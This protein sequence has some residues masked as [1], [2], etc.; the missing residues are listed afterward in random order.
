M[1]KDWKG[2]K[3]TTGIN[4][5]TGIAP[6]AERYH[7]NGGVRTEIVS[8]GGARTMR[9]R[10]AWECPLDAYRDLKIINEAEYKAGLKFH[11]AYYGAVIF[12]RADFRPTSKIQA[13]RKPTKSDILLK[14][15]YVAI[16]SEDMSVIIDICGRSKP[17]QSPR[18]MNILK[19]GL[20]H[21]ATHWKMAAREV[22]KRK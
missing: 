3:K 19:R 22:C 8:E 2:K 9:Y 17:A 21:L 13:D 20:G 14:K 10:A 16:P 12:V 1:E 4:V 6:T 18:A 5:R 15:V 11:Q 7:R